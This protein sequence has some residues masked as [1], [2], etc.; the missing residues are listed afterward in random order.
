MELEFEVDDYPN[1]SKQFDVDLIPGKTIDHSQIK[2]EEG[3]SLIPTFPDK[4]EIDMKKSTNPMNW[5][6][7][8]HFGSNRY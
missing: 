7:K 2:T 6:I 4:A 5:E 1:E 3:L 8:I